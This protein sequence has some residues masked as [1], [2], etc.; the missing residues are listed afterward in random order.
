MGMKHFRAAVFDLDGTLLDH[1]ST[2][3]KQTRSVLEFL[4]ANGVRVILSSG[5]PMY[6]LKE[7]TDE[8]IADCLCSINGQSIQYLH[9]HLAVHKP[10]L[11]YDDIVRIMDA[12]K[13]YPVI[14]TSGDDEVSVQW[15]SSTQKLT[16][17]L[18][19]RAY[20]QFR[21]VQGWTMHSHTLLSDAP[22][23]VKAGKVCIASAPSV[24]RKISRQLEK[25]YAC[26]LVGPMWLEVMDRSVSK[27]TALKE[28]LDH[29][30]I[31]KEECIAFGDGEN[32][33]PLFEA[34]GYS[35]A[36]ANA[37]P[38]CKKHADAIAPSN[39]RNGAAAWI[40]AHIDAFL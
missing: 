34:A 40:R 1:T 29:Y 22:A 27:G 16:A 35:V 30:G 36:M 33:I 25:D 3:T 9:P 26:F 23:V 8:Q 10:S 31:L 32:D 20:E 17:W 21:R 39:R 28:I 2:L 18:Y 37:M 12:A 6:S 13:G 5:R 15:A 38:A 14:F 4:R 7:I 11:K 19:D 24:I